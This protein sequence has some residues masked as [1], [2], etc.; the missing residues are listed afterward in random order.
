MSVQISTLG[1][2]KPGEDFCHWQNQ[3]SNA[4]EALKLAISVY[5]DT[6][7]ELKEISEIIEKYPTEEIDFN[8]QMYDVMIEGPQ[9][10]EQELID[11]KLAYIPEW[12][13]EQIDEDEEIEYTPEQIAKM[14]ELHKQMKRINREGK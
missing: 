6:V 2:T 9:E 8:A 4:K 1:Y 14:A 13:Q 3:T 5:E 7:K 10:L 11:K 12:I